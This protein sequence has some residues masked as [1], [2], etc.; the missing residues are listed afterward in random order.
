MNETDFI[1]AIV[2][3]TGCGLLLDVN[4]VLVSAIN[5]GYAALD[6]LSDFPLDEV[7]EVHLAGHTRQSD[8]EGELL[9]IG[10]HPPD[11]ATRVA[12][13]AVDLVKHAPLIDDIEKAVLGKRVD[14]RFMLTDVPPSAT[15]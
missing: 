7:A 5:H 13:A 3:R 12:G 14:S 11:D 10:V 2:R 6:Y 9:L 1:R 8:D 4:N 15:A